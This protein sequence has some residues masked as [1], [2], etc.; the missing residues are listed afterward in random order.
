MK[1]SAPFLMLG[2]VVVAALLIA[3]GPAPTPA[4]L[5]VESDW[6]GRAAAWFKDAQTDVERRKA[7]RAITQAIKQPCRYCHTPDWTGYTDKHLI[8]KQM[9]ALS[10]ENDV[11]CADCH[12]GK[13]EMTALGETSR[14]MWA[15]ARSKAVDCGHCHVPK[16]KFKTL[17]AAGKDWQSA[18]P[19]G[20][21]MPAST[22]PASTAPASTP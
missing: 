14:V 5:P 18:H 21:E 12:A 9:M 19:K 16:A 15:L 11:A 10:V 22:A 6:K 1:E 7:M 17:N 8:S 20:F 3:A 4:P 13:V 2:L